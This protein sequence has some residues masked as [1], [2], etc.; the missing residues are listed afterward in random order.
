[1]VIDE[2]KTL[3]AQLRI[4]ANSAAVKNT[5]MFGEDS[6]TGTVDQIVAPLNARKDESVHLLYL[7]RS[8][9]PDRAP[10]HQL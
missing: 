2:P 6:A 4:R 1:M 8:T 10:P 5:G 3:T 7:L 9:S